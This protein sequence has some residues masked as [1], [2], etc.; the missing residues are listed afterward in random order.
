MGL[1]RDAI[2]AYMVDELCIDEFEVADDDTLLFSSGLLDSFSMINLIGFI[3]REAS[4]RVR[5]TEV[6]LDNLDSLGRI[7]NYLER[8]IADDS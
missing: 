1:G 2:I 5:P 3:E 4:I 8:R 6:T 7:M